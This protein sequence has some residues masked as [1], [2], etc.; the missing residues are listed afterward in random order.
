MILHGDSWADAYVGDSVA[1][2]HGR[3]AV[4]LEL[5]PEYA[6]LMPARIESILRA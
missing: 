6:A 5:N 4:M 2:K 1:L 3:S